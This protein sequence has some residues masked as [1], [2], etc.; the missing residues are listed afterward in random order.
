VVTEP[1]QGI[2]ALQAGEVIIIPME[3]V[4]GLAAD[5]S[6]REPVER[7]YRLKGRSHEQPSALVASSI[8]VLLACVPELVGQAESAVRALLPGPYTLVL[9]N[10]ARRFP[11]LTGTRPE[12]IGIR[13]PLLQGVARAVL[14]N[15]GTIA[16][17]SANHPGEPDACSVADI[18]LDLVRQCAAVIDG[19]R[20]PGVAST[21][22]DLTGAEPVIVRE[23]AVPARE[24]LARVRV[25]WSRC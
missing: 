25:G 22:V 14:E 17:T 6:R 19:G 4:Y 11:W 24:A 21:V 8:E 7:L 18:P 16:A 15:A 5:G 9:P 1:S 13:V 10:P 12:A 3:T 2:A 23:G 20:L